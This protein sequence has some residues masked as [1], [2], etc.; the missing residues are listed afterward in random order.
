LLLLGE[1]KNEIGQGECDPCVQ[2]SFSFSRWWSQRQVRSV[3]SLSHL[4]TNPVDRRLRVVIHRFVLPLF[5]IAGP[6]TS[7]HGAILLGEHWIVQPLTD[8]IW[9]GVVPELSLDGQVQHVAQLFNSLKTGLTQLKNKYKDIRA[10]PY[11]PFPYITSYSIPDTDPPTTMRFTYKKRLHCDEARKSTAVFLG[12]DTE[13][14]QIFIKFTAR[15]GHGAHRLLT[16]KGYAPQL[17]HCFEFMRGYFIAVMEYIEGHDMHGRSFS[18]GDLDRVRGAKDILHEAG[19]VFGDLRPNNI[20]KPNDESGVLL[21]DFDWCGKEGESRYPVTVN[22]DCRWH[23]DVG[24]GAIMK[25]EHD[26]YLFDSLTNV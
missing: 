13:G 16:E 5:S 9:T 2:A 6:W 17:L 15:Y 8:L 12:E 21:V 23:K 18:S 25:K 24:P 19:I 26:D 1:M 11:F 10:N 4:R 3:C 22:P 20:M 14:K 7:V